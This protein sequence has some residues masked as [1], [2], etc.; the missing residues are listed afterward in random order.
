[1]ARSYQDY[2][3]I[4][5]GLAGRTCCGLPFTIHTQGTQ[6][7]QTFLRQIWDLSVKVELLS[8]GLAEMPAQEDL[9]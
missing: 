9:R 5:P 4:Q 1:M 3:Q 8:S 7:C 6:R 2:G